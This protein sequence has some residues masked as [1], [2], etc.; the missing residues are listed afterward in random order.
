MG[1][2]ARNIKKDEELNEMIDVIATF[3]GS[4]IADNKNSL[5]NKE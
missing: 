4:A 3:S 2:K 1:Y 5:I